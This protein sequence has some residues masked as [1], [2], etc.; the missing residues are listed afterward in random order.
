MREVKIDLH[1]LVL[2][3][4]QLAEAVLVWT[5]HDENSVL[6]KHLRAGVIQAFE[7]TYELSMKML[8]RVLAQRSDSNSRLVELS[9][10]DLLRR[11]ADAGLLADMDAWKRWR[12]L[13]NLTSHTY[14]EARAIEVSGQCEAFLGDAR[15]LLAALQR[16][17]NV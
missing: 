9:F 5:E 7:Y 12:E 17:M 8:R 4:S 11:S 2:A 6:K 1:P 15:A 3:C 16:D 10:N 14:S 13:R